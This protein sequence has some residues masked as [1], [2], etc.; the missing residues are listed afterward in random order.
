MHSLRWTFAILTACG[1]L[2]PSSWTSPFQK[3]LYNVYTIFMIFLTHMLLLSQILDIVLNVKN[4]DEFCDNIY[5]TLAV[6][7]SCCKMHNIL[8]NKKKITRLLDT[9]R[10]KP[11]LPANASEIEIRKECDKTIRWNV[12][13]YTGLVEFCIL[14]M[15]ATSFFRDFKHRRLSFRMWVPYDY[16]STVSYTVTYVHQ[17]V[18]LTISSLLNVAGDTLFSSLLIHTYAQ[19]K[20]LEHRLENI[21]KDDNHPVEECAYYHR[22]IYQLVSQM[23]TREERA[24]S[25]IELFTKVNETF[26]AVACTQ[27]LVSTSVV[28]FN[29]YQMTQRDLGSRFIETIMYATCMLTEIFYYCWYGNEV[30]LKSLDIPDVIIDSDWMCLDIKSQKM[31]L[32][33]MKRAT[34]PIEFTSIHVVSMNLES[35]MSLLKSSYS[36]YNLMQRS[37]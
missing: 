32:M 1:C 18:S 3:I 15:W 37:E 4:Q 22:C 28:C 31:L 8:L 7:V 19:L 35:F 2:R 29:L 23:F 30:K 5:I 13:G 20:M 26:K 21:A 27:F 36:A 34:I 14:W 24:R 17:A 25:E 12:I 16:S 11:F 9:L 6:F 33:I 10:E